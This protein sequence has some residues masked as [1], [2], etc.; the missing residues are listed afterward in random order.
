[1]SEEKKKETT[2][3]DDKYKDKAIRFIDKNDHYELIFTDSFNPPTSGIFNG[4]KSYT[5]IT[6]IVN[7]MREADKSKELHIFVGSYGGAVSCLNMILQQVQEF[8]YRVGINLGMACSCGFMLLSY[9]HERYTS[10][11]AKWMYHEMSGPTWGKVEENSRITEFH[12]NWWDILVNG[13]FCKQI[14]T[15]KELEDGK[16]TEVWLTGRELIR[17]RVAYDYTEYHKRSVLSPDSSGFYIINDEVWRKEG[18]NYV[19]Y[20]KQKSEPLT[21]IELFQRHRRLSHNSEKK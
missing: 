9:C 21:R 13:S 14:L 6:D 15:E 4:D 8:D 3:C 20:T 2:I 1:M 16:L 11:Y 5:T 12:K 10:P 7:D 17:R 19:R 18:D